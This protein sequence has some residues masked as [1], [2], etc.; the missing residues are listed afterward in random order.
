MRGV[1]VKG[2]AYMILYRWQ[3]TKLVMMNV[4]QFVSSFYRKLLTTMLTSQYVWWVGLQK[5]TT[6]MTKITEISMMASSSQMNPSYHALKKIMN[7]LLELMILL[8]LR[9][10][11]SYRRTGS[12]HDHLFHY[13]SYDY[14]D[15]LAKTFFDAA[16]FLSPHRH[17]YG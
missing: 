4:R 16:G 9:K 3:Q 1:S 17:Q 7:V 8:L 2:N 14:Y 6:G 11:K 5:R 12:R 10:Q 15:K 13:S